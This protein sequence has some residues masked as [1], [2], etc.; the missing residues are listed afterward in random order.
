MPDLPISGLPA[1]GPLSAA[2]PLVIVQAGVT[3][4][5]DVGDVTRFGFGGQYISTKLFMPYRS[6]IAIA[7]SAVQSNTIQSAP[8]VVNAPVTVDAIAYRIATASTGAGNFKFAIYAMD[9]NGERV[10]G[11]PIA[12][13]AAIASNTAAGNYVTA[14]TASITLQPGEVYWFAFWADATAAAVTALIVTANSGTELNYFRASPSA[15]S[16]YFSNSAAAG[17]IQ[18]GSAFGA[19]PDLTGVAP[20]SANAA[21]SRLPYFALRVA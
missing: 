1:A 10:T 20:G 8:F 17:C 21:S 15:T 19:W 14:L 18:Y 9:A 5:T 3:V 6:G 2:D 12:E 16:L 4:Q 11:F 13:T 7:G